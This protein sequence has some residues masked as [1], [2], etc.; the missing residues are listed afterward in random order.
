MYAANYD[1]YKRDLAAYKAGPK[2]DEEQDP[3][4]SQLQQD[5]AGAEPE[6]EPEHEESADEESTEYSSDESQSP[7][8]VKEKT[9]PRTNAKRRR[10]DVKAKEAD[11]PAKSP[12]KRGRK[13]AEP[14]SASKEKTP[15]DSKRKN[16]KRKSEA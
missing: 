2:T 13:A 3:A 14:V 15:A 1:Q 7:S 10:S 16:K 12:V 8:P 9:P 5:F 11:T 6:A 4:A